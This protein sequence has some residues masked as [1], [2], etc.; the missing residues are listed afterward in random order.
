VADEAKIGKDWAADELDAIVEDYFAML[1]AEQ[2]GQPYVKSRHAE[3]LMA[4]IGR[5]HRS[6][7]F[8]HMNI[9][10]VLAE[11]SL[12]TIRGYKA[13]ANYQNA[14][15]PAIGRYL[16]AHPEVLSDGSLPEEVLARAD[17]VAARAQ[18]ASFDQPAAGLSEVGRAFNV[19]VPTAEC[20]LMVFEE[21]P[22]LAPG[23][24][25]RP[26]G[27]ERLVRKF[28][29]AGRDARNRQLGYAGEAHAFEFECQRLMKAGRADLARKVQWTSQELGDGAGYDIRS[30][31]LD[32]TDRLIEVKATRGTRTTPFFVSRTELEMS[33]EASDHWQL[34][35]VYALSAEPRFF[36]LK[37]PLETS[38]K[39][40][41]ENWRAAFV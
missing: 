3:A 32:G 10:A 23:D 21:P 19:N 7:E 11:L 36:S 24:I 13:K 37:P 6:V 34:Y 17:A 39:L 30:F 9:S 35:R 26:E 29:P 33:R 12:P 15:F 8:K 20:S 2:Q 14:I 28:D 5:T 22:A 25:R 27:L 16:S 18:A 41:A 38:V 4:Q 40:E 31:E 1:Q